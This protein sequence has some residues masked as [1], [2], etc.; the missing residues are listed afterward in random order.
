M[1]NK[2]L[3]IGVDSHELDPAL[4]PPDDIHRLHYLKATLLGET[5][6]FQPEDIVVLLNPD[7]QQMRQA[8]AIFSRNVHRRDLR[9]LYFA[10]VGIL[11]P[12]DGSESAAP[13]QLYLAAHGSRAEHLADSALSLDFLRGTLN[14][15]Q[16][17]RQ[18]L[19]FDCDWNSTISYGS[20]DAGR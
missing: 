8:I 3:F 2:A 14:S 20:G 17:E 13:S 18:V 16:S 1:G 19:V 6:A 5:K 4:C 15:S 11:A 10:T 7:V 9:L 12:Q